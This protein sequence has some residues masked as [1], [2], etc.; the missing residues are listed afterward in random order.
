MK[1]RYIIPFNL[2][3]II[4]LWI[5]KD[6]HFV[7]KMEKRMIFLLRCARNKI[8]NKPEGCIKI[9]MFY[10]QYFSFPANRIFKDIFSEYTKLNFI[11]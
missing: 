2:Y 4:L 6:I 8:L 11:D 1:L 7:R 5:Q 9:A 10:F 3:F